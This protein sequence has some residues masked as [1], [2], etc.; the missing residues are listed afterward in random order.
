M[1]VLNSGFVVGSGEGVGL[2]EDETPLERLHSGQQSQQFHH[3]VLGGWREA[4][5]AEVLEPPGLPALP[6]NPCQGR[7]AQGAE[8]QR[9]TSDDVHTLQH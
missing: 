6:D 5:Q 1:F 3:I 2:G 7:G 4:L 9:E 8:R